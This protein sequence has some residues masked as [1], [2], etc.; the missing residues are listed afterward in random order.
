M[1]FQVGL[2]I[3]HPS[4]EGVV[5]ER[6]LGLA[7]VV[8]LTGWSER[9]VFRALKDGRLPA[10]EGGATKPRKNRKLSWKATTVETF[11]ASL[12]PKLAA[13]PEVARDAN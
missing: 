10:P 5:P 8:A 11:L 3:G 9:S 1:V 6:T 7:E 12:R 13:L 4:F 2:A